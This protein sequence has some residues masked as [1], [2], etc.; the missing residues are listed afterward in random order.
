MR[1]REFVKLLGGA[2]ASSDGSPPDTAL[3]TS[4][5]QRI[6]GPPP[7]PGNQRAGWNAVSNFVNWGYRPLVLT[8]AGE[9]PR[10]DGDLVTIRFTGT[11][12]VLLRTTAIS[13]I[14]V[15][16]DWV[17]TATAEGSG[18]KAFQVGPPLPDAGVN[19]V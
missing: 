13:S 14:T 1:R 5:L 2:A 4:V 19:V 6:P 15:N 16:T 10:P 7:V 18:V 8:R 11:Q 12:A 9:T 3:G 17:T